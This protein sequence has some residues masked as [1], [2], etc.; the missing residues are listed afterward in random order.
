[1][2]DGVDAGFIGLGVMGQPMALSLA[3]GGTALTVWNR[4]AARSQVLATAGARVAAS[5]AELLGQVPV[6][7]LMLPTGDAIDSVLGRGTPQF[8]TNVAGHTIVHMGTTSPGYSRSLEAS[9]RAAEGRY[10]EAPVAGSC[11]VAEAGR[12]VAMLAGE[13]ISADLV[14]PLLRPMCQETIMCGPVPNAMQMK[15]AVNLFQITMITGL[16]ESVHF[17]SCRG[18]NLEQLLAVLDVGPMASDVSRM[19]AAKLAARDFAVQAPISGVLKTNQLIA[20][21][22]RESSMASPLLDVCH[23]LYREAVALGHGRS[24]I[25]AVLHA[26]EARTAAVTAPPPEPSA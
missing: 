18:L 22:V 7:I 2:G 20:E 23:S 6:V 13:Q 17:A 5:P 24:D 16:A 11:K 25:S 26:I 1:M 12:L 8:S 19:E 21:A 4:T 9:I 15:L 10:V 3:R 14:R